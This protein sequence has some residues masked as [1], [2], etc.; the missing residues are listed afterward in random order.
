MSYMLKIPQDALTN[1]QVRN[2]Q[3]A[4]AHHYLLTQPTIRYISAL[5]KKILNMPHVFR[6]VTELVPNQ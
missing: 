2:Y 4:T 3:P 6:S 5:I 1:Q